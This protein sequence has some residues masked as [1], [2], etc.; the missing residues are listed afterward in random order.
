[1][2]HLLLLAPT[3]LDPRGWSHVV[4]SDRPSPSQEYSP[5]PND[6]NHGGI[7]PVIWLLVEPRQEGAPMAQPL[8]SARPRP[9]AREAG[10][11]GQDSG[12]PQARGRH[13]SCQSTEVLVLWNDVCC[14]RSSAGAVACCSSQLAG[15]SC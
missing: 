1:M 9:T 2:K 13:T 14:S 15:C 10:N 4:A 7:A 6:S 11:A 5:R 8:S 3:S 12:R